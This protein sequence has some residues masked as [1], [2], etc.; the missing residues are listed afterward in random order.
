MSQHSKPCVIITGA[1]SGIG[2]AAARAFAHDG[3]NVV[4]AARRI[5]RLE[6]LAVEIGTQ[7]MAVACDVSDEQ[8]VRCLIERS[9]GRFGRVDVLINNAGVGL[10]EPVQA[11]TAERWR[12]IFDVNVHAMFY[13][14]KHVV[15]P[16]RQ[17]GGGCI[18]NVASWVGIRAVPWMTAYSAAKFAV[19]GLTEAAR[20][21]LERYGIH[22]CVI[23]PPRVKTEFFDAMHRHSQF[24]SAVAGPVL[25]AE[26]IAQVLVR[27]A[28]RPKPI[29][30]IGVSAKLALWLNKWCRPL[31]DHGVRRYRDAVSRENNGLNFSE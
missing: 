15:A 29:V 2:A 31:V 22:V 10:I 8:Q 13:G 4:M 16:M 5:D 21:E 18:L 19:V 27:T 20:I 28:T 14:I 7:A 6:K 30:T 12:E 24:R 1:S 11:T 9:V 26:K 23:C 3:A 25:S 17:G